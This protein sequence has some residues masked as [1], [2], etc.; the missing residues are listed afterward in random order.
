[1]PADPTPLSET[2]GNSGGGHAGLP[3]GSRGSAAP[4]PLWKL[5]ASSAWR[6]R[7]VC[8][9][10]SA[11]GG[12]RPGMLKK[13]SAFRR[14]ARGLPRTRFMGDRRKFPKKR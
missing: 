2:S 10:V 11:R 7:G 6:N 5:A 8:G 3:A 9:G 12:S 4:T 14:H 1:V 13:R